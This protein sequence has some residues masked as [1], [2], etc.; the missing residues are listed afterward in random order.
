MGVIQGIGDFGLYAL[1][2]QALEALSDTQEFRNQAEIYA[3]L[4]K[5]QF[6][7][8]GNWNATTN[9]PTLTAD[10]TIGQTGERLQRYIIT[11]PGI[12]PFDIIDHAAG[13]E[14]GNG[15]LIQHPNGEWF[16]DPG[17]P[18][19]ANRILPFELAIKFREKDLRVVDANGMM[20]FQVTTA[21]VTKTAAIET[22]TLKIGGVSVNLSDYADKTLFDI[23]NSLFIIKKDGTLEFNDPHGFSAAKLNAEGMFLFA[24]LFAKA[25]SADTLTTEKSTTDFLTVTGMSVAANESGD[26]EVKDKNGYI[27]WSSKPADPPR[28]TGYHA[29]VNHFMSY[30]QSLS[31][32]QGGTPITTSTRSNVKTFFKGPFMYLH[33][34]DG[35]RYTDFKPSV[36]EVQE[37][38]VTS[39]GNEICRQIELKTGLTIDGAGFTYDALVS[40]AGQGGYSL[41]QLSKGGNAYTRWLQGITNGKA[42]ATSKNKTYN[43]TSIL[44]MQG[45]Y[46]STV[47]VH[48]SVY[49][50]GLRK[51]RKDMIADI[52][53][54]NPAQKNDL[55]FLLYQVSSFNKIPDSI[56][57]PDIALMQHNMAINE[58]GFYPGPVMYTYN[59]VDDTHLNSGDEYAKIGTLAGYITHQIVC[60]GIEWKGLHIKSTKI[61]GRML[62]IEFGVPV[63][64]LVLDT[65]WVSDPGHY[66]FRLFNAD[67][68]EQTLSSEVIEGDDVSMVKVIRPNTVRI[69][70]PNNITAGMK[71]TYA[72]NGTVGKSGRTQGARGC[73]RDSQGDTLKYKPGTT[74]FRL[75]NY[76][77]H[78]SHTIKS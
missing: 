25:L 55:I 46:E 47:R 1:L 72:I 7:E 59:Y 17:D 23:L 76:C 35:T 39:M 2:A 30:G 70:S 74:N 42:L 19:V 38:P 65:S 51:L 9:S 4:A 31:V 26:L 18:N 21:G 49:R 69:V 45:E 34:S 66:G 3:S 52:K 6:E 61:E 40:A 60:E 53:T 11:I 75:D 62:D 32:G 44:W 27:L 63:E 37:T 5:N 54:I 73:L 57:N 64:P 28:P 50:D 12:L 78:F 36:E 24:Q 68:T 22:N 20:S 43:A 48:P 8:K 58:P 67:G 33:D 10:A 41:V 13:S 15:Y 77:P 29:D 14:I 16:F 56:P 71:V